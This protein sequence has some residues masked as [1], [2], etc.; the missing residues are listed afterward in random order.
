MKKRI[1]SKPRAAIL[2]WCNNNG[3]T[4]YGQI[5]QCYATQHLV[6]EAGYEPLVVQYR[7]KDSWDLLAHNFSNRTALGRALNRYYERYYNR[8][9]VEQ[10]KSPRVERFTAFIQRYIPL[11]APCYTK[12]MVEDMTKDCDILVCGSDQIWNPVCFD[13]VWFLDFG[14]PKQKR[15]ACAPSG[16]FYE[17]E[18]YKECYQKMAFLIE[19]LDEVNVRERIGADI[20][21]KYVK[22]EIKVRED[23][24]LRLG[25][26]QW[27]KVADKKLVEG[28]YIFCYLLGS[29]SPY[30][31]ILRELKRGYQAEK[32]VY[33]PT[34]LLLEEGYRE[35]L[36]YEDA[37]PAQF[38]SLI[39][40]A[41]AVCTDSFHG[42]VMA[43]QYGIPFY[44]VRRVH[45][46]TEAFGG[47][48]RIDNL[49]QERGL[50][51]RWVRNV[52][53]IR[54]MTF[55]YDGLMNKDTCM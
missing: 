47:G 54:Q 6:R 9:V 8:Q 21:R 27:D 37:G 5:L 38:L 19:Q 23:P 46:G 35:F 50:S 44:N 17:K 53:D 12:K 33:I 29:L 28:N 13:P 10:E 16:I 48:E 30:Q 1:A 2:T 26:K 34:N 7:K 20:L 18:E 52:S 4:N 43:L 22:K 14:T 25:Q 24:T 31:M 11:S 40:Y 49:L 32:I 15:I 36:K 45:K 39:K 51:E 41:K 55:K 3:P 42:T